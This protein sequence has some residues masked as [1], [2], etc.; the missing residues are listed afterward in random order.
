MTAETNPEVSVEPTREEV[1]K[2]E[3]LVAAHCA[4]WKW[5][6]LHQEQCSE[7]H[8]AVD[9][10]AIG[11]AYARLASQPSGP[12]T[13]QG[14]TVGM[15]P[16][17]GGDAAPADWDGGPVLMV[18]PSDYRGD[19][20]V[21]VNVP[22]REMPWKRTVGWKVIVAYTPATLHTPPPVAQEG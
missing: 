21:E 3:W 4:K 20:F 16:W 17:R 5:P 18:D 22:P 11:L 7:Y 9:A 13:Q 1:K 12:A 8:L 19:A 14:A 6:G 15:V 10:A 2:A